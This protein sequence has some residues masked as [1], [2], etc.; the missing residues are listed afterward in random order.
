M[1]TIMK[2]IAEKIAKLIFDDDFIETELK[3]DNPT[4]EYNQERKY[5]AGKLRY[6]LITPEMEEALAEVLTYG[7]KKYSANSWQKVEPFEDRYYGALRRHL[8]EWRKGEIID[9]E[10]GL[11]HLNHAF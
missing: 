7:A 2:S 5:D 3:T 1:T 8:Q 6:E 11:P 10:S 9:P 4:V